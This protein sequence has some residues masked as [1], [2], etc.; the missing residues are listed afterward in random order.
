LPLGCLEDGGTC[1][2]GEQPELDLHRAWCAIQGFGLRVWGF[3]F[4]FQGLG[5][6]F[7]VR[8][9]GFG[10]LGIR[11]LGLRLQ[12]LGF[13]F[14]VWGFGFGGLDSKFGVEVEGL[15]VWG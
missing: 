15:R 8:D 14:R 4:R 7:K 11:G 3:G 2:I 1:V 6:E 9:F 12:G 13:R 10:G 5:I